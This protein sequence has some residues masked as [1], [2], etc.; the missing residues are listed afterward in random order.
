MGKIQALSDLRVFHI[1]KKQ[2]L[3]YDFL[4]SDEQISNE[5][6]LLIN[7]CLRK[8]WITFDK[9]TSFESISKDKPLDRFFGGEAYEFLLR[10]AC[11]LESEI[12][13]ET[14][15]FGQ[16]KTAWAEFKKQNSTQFESLQNWMQRLFED[17]KDIRTQY[18]QNIGGNNYGSLV[19]KMIKERSVEIGRSK[20][21]LLVGAGN[22]A[23]SILPY[24]KE[25]EVWV[26][27]RNLE[28]ANSLK[29][30]HPEIKIL[31]TKDKEIFGW[32]NA[33]H[34]IVCIPASEKDD[35]NRLAWL[36]SNNVPRSVIH[37]GALKNELTQ[38]NQITG[39]YALDDIFKLQQDLSITRQ[40]Q[41]TRAKKA[42]V[43]RAILR[44][45]GANTAIP[46]GWEDLLHFV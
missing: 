22:L 39:F 41:I 13:G 14:D 11:G 40:T 18:V 9:Q 16:F 12:I 43:E 19:R 30:I 29:E 7:T 10:I 37:L 31:D 44:V 2:I 3:N 17:T 42:C 32:K 26:W 36:H 38:W 5:N 20:P 8:I 1:S 21:I 6:I 27:N 45:L 33:A 4:P 25:N 34:I 35:Q 15:I 24:L 46:H 28:N 23:K